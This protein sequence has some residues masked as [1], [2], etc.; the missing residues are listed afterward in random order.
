M[1]D[2]S[3]NGAN[4]WLTLLIPSWPRLFRP[5]HI[6]L[7]SI[8]MAQVCAIPAAKFFAI[9][10]FPGYKIDFVSEYEPRFRFQIWNW[11]TASILNWKVAHVQGSLGIP[12]LKDTDLGLYWST[13]LPIPSWPLLFRPQQTMLPSCNN[14]QE[15][16]PPHTILIAKAFEPVDMKHSTLKTAIFPSTRLTVHSS[17]NYQRVLIVCICFRIY[18]TAFGSIWANRIFP[19]NLPDFSLVNFKAIFEGLGLRV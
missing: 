19:S 18:S 11:T 15:W 9:K 1:P 5:Q 4:V 13:V 7:S 14:A 10:L 12:W 6:T 3:K 2:T 17:N 8:R 16:S